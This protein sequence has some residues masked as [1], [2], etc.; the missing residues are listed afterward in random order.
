MAMLTKCGICGEETWSDM[1]CPRA[2]VHDLI[3]RR[4]VHHPKPVLEL[5]QDMPLTGRELNERLAE[6]NKTA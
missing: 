5:S 1:D 3:L 2:D 4:Y 6:V